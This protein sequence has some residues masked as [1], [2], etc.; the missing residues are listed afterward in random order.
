MINQFVVY[1]NH[2]CCSD[3]VPNADCLLSWDSRSFWVE[4][5]NI[6]R[7]SCGCDHKSIFSFLTFDHRFKNRGFLSSGYSHTRHDGQRSVVCGVLCSWSWS[8]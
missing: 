8:E 6:G 2:P 1:I 4:T 3:E 5:V 7:G